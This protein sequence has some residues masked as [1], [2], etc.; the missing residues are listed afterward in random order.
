MSRFR[1]H[2]EKFRI[3]RR[4]VQ[5]LSYGWCGRNGYHVVIFTRKARRT[6]KWGSLSL[7]MRNCDFAPAKVRGNI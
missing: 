6:M 3:A 5:I 2:L 1:V 7:C 4:S